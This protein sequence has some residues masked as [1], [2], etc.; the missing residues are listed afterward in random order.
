MYAR[1]ANGFVEVE[2]QDG[3]RC[4]IDGAMVVLAGKPSVPA[5][6]VTPQRNAAACAGTRALGGDCLP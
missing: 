4:W 1:K 2:L 3:R 5:G 6:A